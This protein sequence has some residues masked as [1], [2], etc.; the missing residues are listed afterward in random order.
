MN[1]VIGFEMPKQMPFSQWQDRHYMQIDKF[2]A[3]NEAEFSGYCVINTLMKIADE[4]V[5]SLT[6]KQSL[7]HSVDEILDLYVQEMD[8]TDICK[9]L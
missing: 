2:I 7:R 5:E 1:H 9:K 6:E 8:F 4:Y 3:E